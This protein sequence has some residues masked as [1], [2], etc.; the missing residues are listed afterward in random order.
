MGTDDLSE[1][2]L[3]TF[4]EADTEGVGYINYQQ[5][6]SIFESLSDQ[7]RLTEKDIAFIM[8]EADENQDGVI[9]YNEFVPLAVDLIESIYAKS[10]AD[11]QVAQADAEAHEAAVA[12]LLQDMSQEELENTLVAVFQNADKDGN[13]TLDRKEF[14]ACLKSA[15]LGLKNKQIKALMAQTD[16]DGDGLISYEEFVPTCFDML[17]EVLSK[18]I[19]H[20]AESPE[21]V[22]VEQFLMDNFQAEDEKGTG[23]LPFD[24]L[25]QIV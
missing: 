25:K 12:S 15:D 6:S 11:M 21:L 2:I 7:L 5:L 4:V 23:V 18:E 1:M 17:V 19:K 13:G 9:E 10:T 8:A 24:K 14:Q 3:R 20:D 16:M 22:A